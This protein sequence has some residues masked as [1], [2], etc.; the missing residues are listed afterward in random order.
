MVP[1]INV[2]ECIIQVTEVWPYAMVRWSL[3]HLQ[4]NRFSLHP[5]QNKIVWERLKTLSLPMCD[6]FD[7]PWNM[8][9]IG[10]LITYINCSDWCIALPIEMKVSYS[11]TRLDDFLLFGRL[12]RVCKGY[13]SPNWPYNWAIFEKVSFF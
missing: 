11:V 1:Y 9:C 10:I 6:S 3:H 13:L 7:S 4:L 2:R 5:G 8:L 12:F